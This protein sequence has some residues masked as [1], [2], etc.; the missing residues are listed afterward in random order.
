VSENYSSFCECDF[1]GYCEFISEPEIRKAR[2]PHRCIECHVRILP[3]EDYE[4]VAGKQDG[5]MW[6]SHTCLRC[7][8]LIEWITAHVPCFCREYGGTMSDRLEG[9]VYQA[10]QTPGFAFGLLRRVAAIKTYNEQQRAL[11]K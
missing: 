9:M 6:D 7:I 2:K 4:Y 10:Q 8:A 5:D 11:P 1:D 3:G